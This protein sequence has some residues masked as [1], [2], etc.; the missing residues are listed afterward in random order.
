MNRITVCFFLISTIICSTALAV[1]SVYI[2]QEIENIA[3]YSK[4]IKQKIK[5][6]KIKMDISGNEKES[7]FNI[8]KKTIDANERILEVL[9]QITEIDI[10]CRKIKLYDEEFGYVNFYAGNN[11]N[12]FFKAHNIFETNIISK[13]L[14]FYIE[15]L[16]N[17][18]ERYLEKA[19]ITKI[20]DDSGYADLYKNYAKLLDEKSKACSELNKIIQSMKNIKN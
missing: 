17:Q 16:H 1:R 5:I 19:K 2:S 15:N 18:S 12:N 4:Q 7:D 8:D 6:L 14:P 11:N 3:S 13:A 20:D 10:A 9:N